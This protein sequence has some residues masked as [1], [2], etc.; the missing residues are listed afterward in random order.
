MQF[1]VCRWL[2]A[3]TLVL[4]LTGCGSSAGPQVAADPDDVEAIRNVLLSSSGGADEAGE[5]AEP[6][7]FATIKGRFVFDGTPPD[8][9]E[10]SITKDIEVC[11][12]GGKPVFEP[13]VDVDPSTKGVANVLIFLTTKIPADDPKWVH[14]SYSES[15]EAL[16]SGDRAFD[17]K[18][19]R[20][21]SPI[22]ALRS[23][24]TLEILNS[25][26]VSH[27][28][29]ISPSSPKVKPLNVTIPVGGKVTWTPGGPSKQPIPVSCSIHP[30]MRASVIS[31]D[32]PYFAVS[33]KDGSFEI[34]NVPAGVELEFRLWQAASKWIDGDVTLNGEAQKL[35]RGQIKVQLEPD[36]TLEWNFVLPD[37]LF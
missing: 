6:T 19:C 2:L 11:K 17:Q 32:D 30:W 22:Y 9:I 31:R 5:R 34:K 35:K 3:T 25:D 8:P 7:G 14:D 26:P 15:S 28:T 10:L 4:G 24:Q 18:K 13:Q 1:A 33:A 37:S 29:M 21:L 27:N 16:L 12:P 20:F 23:T 36:Q